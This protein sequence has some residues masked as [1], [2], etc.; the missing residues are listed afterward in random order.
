MKKSILP[1]IFATFAS[2]AFAQTNIP[3]L[4]GIVKQY[5]AAVDAGKS[6][7]VA[8]LL[9]A[10]DATV[11]TLWSLLLWTKTHGL[12]WYRASKSL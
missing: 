10:N 7:E 2:A 5:F 1:L 12:T 11:S 8:K 9:L 6:V 3:R 4:A